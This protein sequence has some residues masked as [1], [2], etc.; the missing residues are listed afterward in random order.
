[1]AAT[2]ALRVL[3]IEEQVDT[4]ETLGR[5]IDAWGFDVRVAFGAVEGM[6]VI[7]QGLAPDLRSVLLSAVSEADIKAVVANLV[8]QA[9]GGDLDAIGLLLDRL[10]GRPAPCDPE[11]EGRLDSLEDVARLLKEGLCLAARVAVSG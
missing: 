6:E 5:L 10:F 4:A 7:D 11:L 3:V 9:K 2:D 8:E 1:M